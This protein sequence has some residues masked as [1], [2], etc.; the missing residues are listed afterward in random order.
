MRDIGTGLFFRGVFLGGIGV[1][2]AA[3]TT[4]FVH[5]KKQKTSPKE[6]VKKVGKASFLGAIFY[7]A[8]VTGLMGTLAFCEWWKKQK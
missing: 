8:G 5:V 7:T 6:I 2:F 3:G 1:A 4:T